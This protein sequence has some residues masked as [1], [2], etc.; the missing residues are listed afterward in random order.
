MSLPWLAFIA[1]LL[2]CGQALCDGFLTRRSSPPTSPTSVEP[3]AAEPDVH[4]VP[5]FL[6]AC[7]THGLGPL[8]PPHT[9]PSTSSK[10]LHVLDSDKHPP[11]SQGTIALAWAGELFH[12]AGPPRPHG[13]SVTLAPD[14]DIFAVAANAIFLDRHL[15]FENH[16]PMRA[17]SSSVLYFNHA[18]LH[19]PPL[20][21]K[22]LMIV[23]RR[24]TAYR[25][26]IYIECHRG[27]LDGYCDFERL[28]PYD[29]KRGRRL[30]R[31]LWFIYQSKNS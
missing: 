23:R 8:C 6:E 29:A 2:P 4:P 7:E 18:A 3:L 21:Y 17:P 14:R 26:V 25:L 10:S 19:I 13:Y 24:I 11:S 20:E 15:L 9:S 22:D 31:V 30:V 5:T 1:A 28:P 27:A 12:T 16:T